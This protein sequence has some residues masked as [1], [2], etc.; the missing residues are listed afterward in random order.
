VF[1]DPKK[2]ANVSQDLRWIRWWHPN[3]IRGLFWSPDDLCFTNLARMRNPVLET[4]K[5]AVPS[6]SRKEPS[7]T[8]ETG[9]VFQGSP[10]RS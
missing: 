10:Y 8:M 4:N 1:L 3:R 6:I 7:K 5:E 2:V 9:K